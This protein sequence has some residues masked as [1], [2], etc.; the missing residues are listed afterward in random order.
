MLKS[1]LKANKSKIFTLLL[2][3]VV[4][5][6][7]FGLPVAA[8][9][10]AD[11]AVTSADSASSAD[12]GSDIEDVNTGTGEGEAIS[13]TDEAVSDTGAG[14]E[15]TTD[16]EQ[17]TGGEEPVDNSG[18]D[19]DLPVVDGTEI[20]NGEGGDEP[21]IHPEADLDNEGTGTTT[22]PVVPGDG[23][24]DEPE[25]ELPGELPV[26]LPLEKA[27]DGVEEFSLSMI[28]YAGEVEL[29]KNIQQNTV[30]PL[31]DTLPVDPEYSWN[32]I[33]IQLMMVDQT[34]SPRNI[35]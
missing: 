3:A 20:P 17:N 27:D 13:D 12:S 32:T 15:N 4:V 26:V 7:A 11:R 6:G 35:P 29:G 34:L 24:G 18:E 8:Y 1:I 30:L 14:E 31:S 33:L 10:E 16:D 5:F 19:T 22:D 25:G 23:G 9:A 21:N 2:V 28:Y